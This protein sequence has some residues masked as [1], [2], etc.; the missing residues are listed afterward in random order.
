MARE[1]GQLRLLHQMSRFLLQGALNFDQVL[2]TALTCATA[3]PALGFNR[4]FLLL[5][6]EARR[7]LCGVTAIG[8]SS[9]EEALQIWR[10]ISDRDM[11]L[12]DLVAEYERFSRQAPSLLLRSVKTLRFPVESAVWPAV[13]EAVRTQQALRDTRLPVAPQAY[14]PQPGALLPQEFAV[15]PLIA[16]DGVIGAIVADNLYNSRSITPEDVQLLATL[17]QLAGLA[18]ANA[19]AYSALQHTQQ[20]LVRA[21]KMAAVGEMAARVSHEIRNPL[22]TVG[23]FARS[24]LRAP[25]DVERVKRNTGIIADEVRRLEELLTDMLDLSHPRTL[26]LRPERLADVLDQALLL[27]TGEAHTDAPV[28]VRKE[29]APNLPPV[30]IDARSLLRAFLNVMRNALQAMPD[31]GML[32]VTTRGLGCQALVSIGDTGGGIPKHVLPTIFTPFVSHR[33]QGTGLGLSITRQIVIEHE[34]HLSVDTTEG[35]GT[36]FTFSL[37]LRSREAL[38]EREVA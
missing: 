13:A 16:K 34:G 25:D 14:Y 12:E 15:A 33:L 2:Y 30:C 38:S 32:T 19:Q 36:T 9:P 17:A 26:A 6:D 22:V 31:G 3:G 23:G 35:Q 21:E 37:P 5:F 27:A 1:A 20:E 29:Y 18:L 7:E 4:A 28:I 24:I 10:S 8:P 11:S